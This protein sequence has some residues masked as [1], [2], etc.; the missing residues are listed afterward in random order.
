MDKLNKN[1]LSWSSTNLIKT[2][3]QI[4]CQ[5]SKIIVTNC[6][7]QIHFLLKTNPTFSFKLQCNKLGTSELCC[8]VYC[9][10]LTRVTIHLLTSQHFVA[11]SRFLLESVQGLAQATHTLRSSRPGQSFRK[12]EPKHD[13]VLP[14]PVTPPTAMQLSKAS[15]PMFLPRLSQQ[16]AINF[17]KHAC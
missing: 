13:F 8:V 15:T 1:P 17:H 3:W 12:S 2:L 9:Q 6:F 7:G 10:R 11:I 16:F 14:R 4:A 5:Q